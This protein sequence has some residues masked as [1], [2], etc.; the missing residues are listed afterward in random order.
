VTLSSSSLLAHVVATST[1]RGS[2]AYTIA[3]LAP[4]TNALGPGAQFTQVD[5]AAFQPMLNTFTFLG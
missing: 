5:A 1:M 4:A 3:Y 2:Y